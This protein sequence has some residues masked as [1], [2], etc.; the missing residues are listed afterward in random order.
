MVCVGA[1]SVCDARETLLPAAYG[2]W[3]GC[4]ALG[5]LYALLSFL[6][7]GLAGLT[8]VDI[9]SFAHVPGRRSARARA[10]ATDLAHVQPALRL[11][12]LF[13]LLMLSGLGLLRITPILDEWLGGPTADWRSAVYASALSLGALCVAAATYFVGEVLPRRMLGRSSKRMLLFHSFWLA[14]YV[15]LARPLVGLIDGAAGLLLRTLGIKEEKRPL[16][17]REEIEHLVEQ[18]TAAGVL[19]PVEKHLLRETLRL[20]ERTVRQIMRPRVELDAAD[21]DT[22]ADEILGVVAMAGFSR[23]PVYEENL[24]HILGY[25]HTKDLLRQHYLGWGLDLRKLSRPALFVPETMTLDRLLILFREKRDQLAIAVDEYGV[26]KGMVALE[27]VIDE[28]VGGLDASADA[29]DPSLVRREDG[30]W[31]VD[32]AMS[33]SEFLTGIDRDDL[34]DAA[35]RNVTTVAGLVLEALGH[36]PR[37]GEKFPWN[38]LAFEVVDMDRQRIDRLLVT[39][40]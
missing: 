38:G 33:L 7:V 11:G 28:L 25:V 4:L 6:Y 36:L 30:S 21:V 17:S 22:P 40:G 2:V 29:D 39:R 19:E 16:V 13:C 9:A 31:L 15:R 35:P 26:T 12:R 1:F 20:G 8:S 18:G 5:L 34:I 23:L 27:D 3:I 24:D 14:T 32:G 10:L 37:T